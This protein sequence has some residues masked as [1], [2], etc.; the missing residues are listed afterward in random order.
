M[1]LW[2]HNSTNVI[3]KKDID[4]KV[5]TLYNDDNKVTT[6]KGGIICEI[7]SEPD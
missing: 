5:T 4:N 3:A 1:S 2:Q 7:E 6:P